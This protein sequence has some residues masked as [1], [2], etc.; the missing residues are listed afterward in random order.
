MQNSL[1]SANQRY[2]IAAIILHWVMALAFILMLCSG[3]AFEN[4]EA[5]PQSLKFNLIQWHKSLGVLLL[6]AVTARLILRLF[7][8]PPA[9]PQALPRHDKLAAR[10]GH[11][12]LYAAMI[13]MPVSGWIMVSSSSYGLPTIVFDWFE[14]PHIPNLSGNETARSLSGNAHE[15]VAYG[16]IALITLHVAAVAKHIIIDRI[17]L[18]PRMGIGKP[19]KDES[20]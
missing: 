3:L 15:Y 19:N 7:L 2:S 12:A 9:Y 17:N 1:S 20:V 11:W 10:A 5:M 8:K 14:W 6:F 13:I 16:F 18:L 4:W